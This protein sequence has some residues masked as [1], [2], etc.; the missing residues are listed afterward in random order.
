VAQEVFLAAF[1]SIAGFTRAGPHSS[2]R[3][4][5]LGIA[6]NKMKDFVRHEARQPQGQGGSDAQGW[7]NQVA[8]PVDDS[9]ALADEAAERVG[10]VRRAL[11][12]LEADFQERTWRA[13]WGFDIDGQPAADVAAELGMTANGVHIAACRVRKRLRDEFGE[14]L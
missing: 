10:V 9:S 3:G 1:K 5:L 12:M 14:L 11:Q 4:W 7:I 13:F 2:F 6:A 8:A